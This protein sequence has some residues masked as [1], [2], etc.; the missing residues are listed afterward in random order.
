MAVAAGMTSSLFRVMNRLSAGRFLVDAG[1]DVSVLSP[2]A[3]ENH[4]NKP[5]PSLEA[6]NGSNTET[7]GI[8][9]VKLQLPSGRFTW[10][11]TSAEVSQTILDANFL[12]ANL[13]L[14]EINT[15]G[16]LPAFHLVKPMFLQ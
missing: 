11:F 16:R 7:Y 12:R 6:A 4:A 9:F 2:S 8:R 10:S 1:A 5:G 13:L 3:R 14:A 15:Q